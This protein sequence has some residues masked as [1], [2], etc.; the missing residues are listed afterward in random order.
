MF[1]KIEFFGAI[2]ISIIAGTA[3][4]YSKAREKFLE[5]LIKAVPSENKD[6]KSK[7]EEKES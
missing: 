5:A 6:E 1:S 7:N 2:G 3:I 4:G